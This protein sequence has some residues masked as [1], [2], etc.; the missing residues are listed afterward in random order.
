MSHICLYIN[1]ACEVVAKQQDVAAHHLRSLPSS[2]LLHE[3]RGS[4][5]L[6]TPTAGTQANLL[7]LHLQLYLQGFGNL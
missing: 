7:T 1:P 2:L 4:G 6:Q 3:P 5:G